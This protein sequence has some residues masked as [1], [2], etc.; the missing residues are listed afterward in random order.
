MLRQEKNDCAINQHKPRLKLMALFPAVEGGLQSEWMWHP[1]GP[2]PL[3]VG[4]TPTNGPES[5]KEK[6]FRRIT[7]ISCFCP[8]GIMEILKHTKLK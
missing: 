2:V 5:L 4:S 7:S 6:H 8:A 3:P 1:N